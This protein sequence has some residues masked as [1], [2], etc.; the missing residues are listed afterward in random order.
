MSSFI[1][2]H[3][4]NKNSDI[5]KEIMKFIKGCYFDKYNIN[6]FIKICCKTGNIC[7]LKYINNKY[8]IKFT[9][10]N[11]DIVAQNGHL[12]TLMYLKTNHN[13]ICT[14]IGAN[15][16]AQYG[17]IHI[18][19]WLKNNCNI[20]CTLNGARYAVRNK[21]L[22]ILVYLNNNTN[23]TNISQYS[24][25]TNYYIRNW[26]QT[27]CCGIIHP[28]N[29]YIPHDSNTVLDSDS[30]SDSGSDSSSDSD[31]ISNTYRSISNIYI[32]SNSKHY[33]TGKREFI[34]FLNYLNNNNIVVPTI[35]RYNL[36]EL[37]KL[38]NN[39]RLYLDINILMHMQDNIHPHILKY[40]KTYDILDELWYNYCEMV[41]IYI[42]FIENNSSSGSESEDN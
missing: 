2:N 22:N 17:Y 30:G 38:W 27:E 24:S 20:L 32:D 33:Y 10:Y 15:W 1:F 40:I 13:I 8:K 29:L 14:L 39:K 25:I 36:N 28:H 18:V 41:K 4:F 37:E 7:M 12:N 3:V 21:H 9:Q 19:I 23:I 35:I 26:I 11:A 5:H 6:Y 31:T 34:F 42:N 16:A